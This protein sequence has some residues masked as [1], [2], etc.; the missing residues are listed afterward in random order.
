MRRVFVDAN[1]LI[2]GAYSRSGASRAVLMLAEVG[3]FKLVVSRQV[4]NEVDRNIRAKL[5][6]AMKVLVE[7]LALLEL[8]IVDDPERPE[9]EPFL[10]VIEEKDAPI[11]V[12]AAAA[13]IDRFI[14]L[15]TKDFTTAAAERSGIP[16]QTPSAFIED[17]RGIITT[18]L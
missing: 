6:G 15:N 18:S 16:V 12:A 11:L 4:L 17:I 8:E 13:M 7:I 2:A 10:E 14:T 9:W 5:P 1:V 3:L